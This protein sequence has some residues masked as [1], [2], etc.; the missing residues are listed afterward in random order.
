VNPATQCRVLG[1]VLNA[2]TA[3]PD[4]RRLL[5]QTLQHLL[6]PTSPTP[7]GFLDHVFLRLAR[8][9]VMD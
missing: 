5:A 7:T 1:Y 8:Q 3:I 2:L 6:P 9:V 4:G